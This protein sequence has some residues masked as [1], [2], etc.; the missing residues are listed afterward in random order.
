MLSANRCKP[1]ARISPIRRAVGSSIRNGKWMAFAHVIAPHYGM[2]R[3]A[4]APPCGVRAVKDNLG[5]R[6]HRHA[7][8]RVNSF[9][10]GRTRNGSNP[11]IQDRILPNTRTGNQTPLILA[12]RLLR[13][14]AAEILCAHWT[15]CRAVLGQQAAY[16]TV[17]LS[18]N[19]NSRVSNR[20]MIVITNFT[21][22]CTP[23]FYENRSRRKMDCD[24]APILVRH[25]RRR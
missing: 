11:C 24:P 3:S 9:A 2:Q 25:P 22:R 10:H 14:R 8:N 23:L 13:M 7:R 16:P 18:L 5:S 21:Q 12:F 20:L 1:S 6:T 17:P 4:V 15:R 19:A